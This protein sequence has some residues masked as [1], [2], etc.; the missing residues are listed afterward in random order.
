MH[1]YRGLVVLAVVLVAS[2]VLWHCTNGNNNNDPENTCEGPNCEERGIACDPDGRAP[3][4]DDYFYCENDIYGNKR[5]EGQNEAV[6]DEG[7]WDCVEQGGI[8]QCEGDHVPDGED[9][10]CVEM[11]DGTVVCRR[12]SYYPEGGTDGYWDCY[13]DGEFRIC[14]FREG[15]SSDGDADADADY[16]EGGGDDGIS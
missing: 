14:T 6:P 3:C 1:T 5:C 12:H 2:L 4:P 7:D 8:I 15:G 10:S 13:F 16:D 9:W 11:D